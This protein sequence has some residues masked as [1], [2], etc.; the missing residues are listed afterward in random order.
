MMRAAVIAG[1]LIILIAAGA[2]GVYFH[3]TTAEALGLIR[4]GDQHYR[5]GRYL[6]ALETYRRSNEV[7]ASPHALERIRWAQDALRIQ[8][9]SPPSPSQSAGAAAPPLTAPTTRLAQP[10]SGEAGRS[11]LTAGQ[12]RALLRQARFGEVQELMFQLLKEK[13]LTRSGY[14]YA[15]S[16]LR[17]SAIDLDTWQNKADLLP[18]LDRWVNQDPS[19]SMAHT[20]RGAFHFGAAWKARGEGSASTVTERGRGLMREHLALAQRDLETAYALDTANPLPSSLMTSIAG[21]TGL[22]LQT[23]EL[24]F[25]RA[26]Q[27]DPTFYTPH[28]AKLNY[29]MPKWRGSEAAMFAFARESLA[30]AP[31]GS[32]LPHLLS[33]AHAEKGRHLVDDER[34]YLSNGDVWLEIQNVY[35]RLLEDFPQSGEWASEYALLARRAGKLEVAAKQHDLALERDPEE[36]EVRYERGRFFEVYLEDLSRALKEYTEASRIEPFSIKAL[37]GQG[38]LLYKTKQWPKAIVTYSALIKLDPENPRAYYHRAGGNFYQRQYQE[39]VLDYSQAIALKPDYKLAYQWRAACYERLG[40]P[41]KQQEDL[42]I[43]KSLPQ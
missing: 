36:L 20:F 31:R 8:P 19:S 9:A 39:A 10:T 41:D 37:S 17:N 35:R 34:R 40:M 6:K 28:W 2:V 43:L 29:L 16:V 5:E 7:K 21:L 14:L 4:L 27:Y 11:W 23:M 38:M 15:Y 42:R 18:H 25:R 1:L 13:R 24:H 22:D 30:Q 26:R 3:Q 12:V 32:A 33:E